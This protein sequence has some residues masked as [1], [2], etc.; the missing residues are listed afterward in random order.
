MILVWNLR[1]NLNILGCWKVLHFPRIY[2]FVQKTCVWRRSPFCWQILHWKRG[3]SKTKL[4]KETLR[5]QKCRPFFRRIF[6]IFRL[7]NLELRG[8]EG[9]CIC[10]SIIS[11]ILR[12]IS[13]VFRISSQRIQN[14]Q[15]LLYFWIRKYSPISYRCG[16]HSSRCVNSPFLIVLAKRLIWYI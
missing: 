10:F 15:F 1:I 2:S 13:I 4:G 3:L 8:R 6:R 14:R 11:I 12:W 5:A 9:F 7:S 16:Q